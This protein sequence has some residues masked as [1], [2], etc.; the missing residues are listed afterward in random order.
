MTDGDR[1]RRLLDGRRG[2]WDEFVREHRLLVL[3]AA[4]AAARRFGLP[5]SDADDAASEVF[6]ELLKD[7]KRVLRAYRGESALSTWLTVIAYRVAAREF[8]RRARERESEEK[9]PARV[10]PPV[11]DPEALA[12]LAKLPERDRRALVMFHVEGATYREIAERLGIPATHVGM[13]LLRARE[14]LARI[15]GQGRVP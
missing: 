13:V 9:K 3:K 15:L 7:D 1:V 11:R 5:P 4:Q 2:E 12:E 8:A 10:D 6:V 14:A